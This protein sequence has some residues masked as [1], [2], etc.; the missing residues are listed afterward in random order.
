[1]FGRRY[2]ERDETTVDTAILVAVISAAASLLAAAVTFWLTKQKEREAEWRTQ[3]L[4]HYRELLDAM[5][6]IVGSDSTPDGQRRWAKSTNTIALVASQ[7]VLQ[8]LR[9]YQSAI[10][11]S[12]PNPSIEAHDLALKYL[13]LAIRADLNVKPN[14]DPSTFSFQLWCSG[15]ND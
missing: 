2:K 6:G 13:I 15:A 8:A 10:A 11:K 4:A 3:K 1:L 9:E 5:A 7:Q 14:D 12:N